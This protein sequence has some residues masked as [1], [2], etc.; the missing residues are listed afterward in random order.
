MDYI[1]QFNKMV[2]ISNPTKVSDG[3]GGYTETYAAIATDRWASVIDKG[4][5]RN[6]TEGQLGQIDRKEIKIFY[7]YDL[8]VDLG[9]ET[10]VNYGGKDYMVE[11]IR[12]A[13]EERIVILLEVVALS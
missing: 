10:K 7:D 11:R 4:G 8:W 1:G 13:N 5:G 6:Y 2:T 12:Q 9:L 3:A